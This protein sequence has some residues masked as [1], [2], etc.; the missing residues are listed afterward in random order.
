MSGLW[1]SSWAGSQ[2]GHVTEPPLPQAL[3]HFCPCNSFRQ[4]QLWVRGFGCGMGNPSLTWCPVFLLDVCSTCSL[5]W[6]YG[7][8]SKVPLPLSPQSLLTPRSLVPSGPQVL[9][10]KLSYFHFVVVVVVVGPQGFSPVF[11]TQYLIMLPL[12]PYPSSSLPP[13]SL[14]HLVS[15][16]PLPPDCLFHLLKVNII[17]FKW[18]LDW[19]SIWSSLSVA[20]LLLRIIFLCL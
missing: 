10:P 4:E 7:I 16:L 15:S 18:I 9:Y 6:L 19:I 14:I 20:L 11:C 1:V 2:F 17:F 13:C 12:S 5:S 3:L 8:L